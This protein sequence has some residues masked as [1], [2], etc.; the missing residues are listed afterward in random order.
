MC[1]KNQEQS[2]EVPIRALGKHHCLDPNLGAKL[3]SDVSNISVTVFLH[4]FQIMDLIRKTSG[5]AN[6]LFQHRDDKLTAKE[7]QK[8]LKPQFYPI[9]SNR[10]TSQEL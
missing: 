6:F 2:L 7:L 9:G 3:L 5:M 4:F 1:T 10:R 8:V